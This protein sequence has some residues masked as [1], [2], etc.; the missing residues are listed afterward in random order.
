[1]DWTLSYSST[2]TAATCATSTTGPTAGSHGDRDFRHPA[3]GSSVRGSRFLVFV[4]LSGDLL[5]RCCL[6]EVIVE[7]DPPRRNEFC[8]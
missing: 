3:A 2:N 6:I 5:F 8:Q 1:L 7:V 4:F